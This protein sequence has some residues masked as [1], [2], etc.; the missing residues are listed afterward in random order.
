MYK[1]KSNMV[2]DKTIICFN[3]RVLSSS[4]IKNKISV[5]DISG[6]RRNQGIIRRNG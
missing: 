6:P 5:G 2:K 4:N 3:T 1:I